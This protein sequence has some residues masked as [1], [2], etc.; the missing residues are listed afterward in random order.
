MRDDILTAP[1]GPAFPMHSDALGSWPG[2]TKR[3][4]YAMHAPISYA[5]AVEANGGEPDLSSDLSIN[6]FMREWAALRFMFADA[7]LDQSTK[8][9]QG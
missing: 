6:G 3:E 9:R 2:M 1:D 8:E 4:I 7:M 5:M